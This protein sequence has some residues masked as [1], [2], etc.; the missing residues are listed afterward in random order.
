MTNQ[1]FSV[2]GLHC[3]GC[4][5]T[6]STAIGGMSTVRSVDVN[7]DTKGT[8]LV[9]VEAEPPVSR[10]DVQAV[11]DAEGNFVVVC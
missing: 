1:V 8:S 11:L 7:L 5:E 9:T 3:H 6:V 4:A 2:D 10:A